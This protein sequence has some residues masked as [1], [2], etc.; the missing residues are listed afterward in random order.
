LLLLWLLLLLLLSDGQLLLQSGRLRNCP[1]CCLLRGRQLALCGRQ[2]LLH[3]CQL[4]AAA[5]EGG[6][7]AR[8]LLLQLLALARVR[9]FHV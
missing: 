2:L 7:G 6:V 8:Q 3:A 1:C 9:C 5:P 4:L